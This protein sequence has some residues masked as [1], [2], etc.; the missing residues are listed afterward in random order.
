MKRMA[1][2]TVLVCF[3]ICL[4]TGCGKCQDPAS[5]GEGPD[6]TIA[7]VN[8][9]LID[10]LGSEAIP[11]SVVIIQNQHIKAVGTASSLDIPPG[12]Q[13]IDVQGSY[14]LPGFINAHV[15][16]GYDE[17]NLQEWANSG[18][19]SVRDLGSFA[20]PP[21]QAFSVR[22]ELL[23]DN[24]NARLVAAGP[25]VTTVGG[26][27]NYSVT[28]PEDAEEKINELIDAGADLIKIA[29]EDN[30]QGRSW[31]MLSMTEVKSIVETAHNRNRLVSAH[32]SRS[33]HLAMAIEGGADDVAH[34]V[35]D[36][37]PDSLVALMI[38]RDTYWVPTLELWNGV[39]QMHE[40]DWA[41]KAE[42][43]LRRF[44]QSG[45]KVALGTD[46]DGYVTPFELGMPLLEMQLMQEAGMTSMQIIVA[47]TRHAA[48][49]CGLEN[50][51]GTI[52]AGKIADIVIVKDNPL[53]DIQSM[54]TV[55]MVI[56]NGEIV[57]ND[58]DRLENRSY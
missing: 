43:N 5:S 46:Y 10:G 42:S 24:K 1:I 31:P 57:R 14:V 12:A 28:S 36:N 19:T 25:L 4:P 29:I 47:G 50:E 8:C 38:A 27:G 7:V 54:S 6:G 18:I 16:G 56:H 26:Y 21:A 11:N 55:Q 52:Q 30:L 35:I 53:D 41:V 33:K 9:F 20:H 2:L 15:H 3:S 23:T 34:M 45:G 22:N 39:S 44:V 13:V 32:I 48:H 49:V 37:L 58:R 17:D 51:L 40:L